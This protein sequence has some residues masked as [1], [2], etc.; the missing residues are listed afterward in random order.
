[1]AGSDLRGRESE[2]TPDRNSRLSL[3][4]KTQNLISAQTSLL[5]RSESGS[6][7]HTQGEMT[8]KGRE[9]QEAGISG[10]VLEAAKHTENA[11]NF[12]SYF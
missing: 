9:S 11:Y 7:A 2:Q 8:T 12:V 3:K 10:A 4:K 5:I 1:M 6:L